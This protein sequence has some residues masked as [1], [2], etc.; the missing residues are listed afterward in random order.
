[1]CAP[2]CDEHDAVL[3]LG[4]G[5]FW[6]YAAKPPPLP[7]P[8]QP[9]SKPPLGLCVGVTELPVAAEA[10]VN[11]SAGGVTQ[12]EENVFAASV[13]EGAF[14]GVSADGAFEFRIPGV[15]I[16]PYTRT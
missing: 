8:L 14:V 10:P 13:G 1:M 16:Y 12:S 7:L 15:L 5:S 3:A 6:W 9:M 2:L 4:L 11:E